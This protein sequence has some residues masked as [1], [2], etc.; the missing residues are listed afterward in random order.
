[1]TCM[2]MSKDGGA[3]GP[4]WLDPHSGCSM[5]EAL[6]VSGPPVTAILE[7]GLQPPNPRTGRYRVQGHFDDAEARTCS[8]VPFGVSVTSP[9]GPPD[10][11]AVIVCRQLIVA[12]DVQPLPDR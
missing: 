6:A 12:T 5:D 1:M 10:P 8:W 7:G 3:A 2:R 9:V 11:G 4:S